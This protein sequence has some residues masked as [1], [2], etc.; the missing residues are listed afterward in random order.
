MAT[1]TKQELA[2]RLRDQV[3]TLALAPGALLDE[4]EL[5]E[6]F[7]VSR[8][9]LREIVQ[10]LSGEGYLELQ[11]NRGAKVAPMDLATIRQFFQA[12]PMIYAAVARLAAENATDTHVERLGDVQRAYRT[13]IAADDAPETAMQNHRFHAGIG[14]MAGS[15]YLLPSLNRLL[16]DHTRI[17]QSFYAR[18]TRRDHTRVAIAAD[19]HDAMIDA[20]RARDPA[21]AV[22][23]TLEHWTLSRDEME[24]YVRP[25]PLPHDIDGYGDTEGYSDAV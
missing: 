22:S 14:D 24:R 9:P 1:L 13:A 18:Q 25:D 19:Q 4:V 21:R 12:A 20:F 10:R 7:G 16:I 3:L 2:A 5:A 23:V 6:R 17:G 11:R 15:P 8:T